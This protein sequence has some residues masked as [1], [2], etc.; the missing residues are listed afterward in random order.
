[1]FSDVFHSALILRPLQPVGPDTATLL[2]ASL[3]R[4]LFNLCG[5]AVTVERSASVESWYEEVEGAF[6]GF[7]AGFCHIITQMSLVEL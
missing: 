3:L 5:D 2:P 7:V 6:E 4:D 1:L